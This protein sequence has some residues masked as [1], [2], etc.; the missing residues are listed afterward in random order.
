M[1]EAAAM[2]YEATLTRTTG[3]G[4]LMDFLRPNKI[5]SRQTGVRFDS[6]RPIHRS[7][8]GPPHDG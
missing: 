4:T 2:L 6:G 1:V 7:R 5:R 8:I 3:A